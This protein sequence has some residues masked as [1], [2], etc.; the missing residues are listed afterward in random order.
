MGNLQYLREDLKP[1]VPTFNSPA[2]GATES[3]QYRFSLAEKGPPVRFLGTLSGRLDGRAYFKN[4]ENS[5]SS[6]KIDVTAKISPAQVPL[7]VSGYEE[8]QMSDSPIQNLTATAFDLYTFYGRGGAAKLWE[9][10]ATWRQRAVVEGDF[11]QTIL[12]RAAA[13]RVIASM[14]VMLNPSDASLAT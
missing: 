12:N 3:D 13:H 10:D 1:G 9:D 4:A 14:P 6:S 7:W 5:F 11:Y 2:F 8:F